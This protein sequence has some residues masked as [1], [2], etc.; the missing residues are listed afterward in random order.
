MSATITARIRRELKAAFADAI[1]HRIERG[2]VVVSTGKF[3]TFV[4]EYKTFTFSTHVKEQAEIKFLGLER[5]YTPAQAASQLLYE[6]GY[7]R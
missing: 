3:V 1:T 5:M 4:I 2:S 7:T 6:W